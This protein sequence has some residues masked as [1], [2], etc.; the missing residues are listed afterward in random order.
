MKQ[1]REPTSQILDSSGFP[2][3]LRVADDIRRNPGSNGWR[4]IADEHCWRSA[5]SGETGFIDI[6][7][8]Y[9]IVRWVIE[10]K[11]GAGA[12]WLF[13]APRRQAETVGRSKLLWTDKMPGSDDVLAWVD[14]DS[15]PSSAESS[16]CIVRGQADKEPM[17]ERIA[18]SLV[19]SV[20]ALASEEL[21]FSKPS[22]SHERRIYQPVIVTTAT[23][24]LC[25]FAPSD[26]DLATGKLPH[27]TA[28]TEA[29][30]YVRFR[31]ALS[32]ELPSS[33]AGD[34]ATAHEDNQRTVLIVQ[35][36][37]LAHLLAHWNVI[38]KFDGHWPPAI[39]RKRRDM[40]RKREV[41][42]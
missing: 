36:K 12:R 38:P 37:A 42:T 24:L 8:S 35:A 23:L 15:R 33:D 9:G 41:G 5:T 30:E 26:V 39:E 11:R 3:Q 20:E 22:E 10:C 18:S 27:E 19:E 31:K 32:S 34:L 29:V 28:N 14:L 16:Y 2:F 6:V 4:V 7:A 21:K 40:A 13:L 25:R 1:D 17:L